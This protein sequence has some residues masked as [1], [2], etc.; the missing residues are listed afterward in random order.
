[1]MKPSPKVRAAFLRVEK[2]ALEAYQRARK[3]ARDPEFRRHVLWVWWSCRLGSPG[4][5]PPL[6]PEG[7]EPEEFRAVLAEADKPE[8]QAPGPAQ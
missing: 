1:M 6:P 2:Q 5:V 4:S 3:E 8:W 7:Q